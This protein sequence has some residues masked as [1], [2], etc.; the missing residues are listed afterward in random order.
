MM[1]RREFQLSA[2]SANKFWKITLNGKAYTVQFGRVGSAGQTQTKKFATTAEAV[3][4]FDRLIQEKLKK[5]YQE[6]TKGAP[7]AA[8]KLASKGRKVK[9]DRV[10]S[11]PIPI[12]A[13]TKVTRSLALRPEEWRW[14]RW[15]N[16]TPLDLPPA[17][18]FNRAQTIEN[19]FARFT[20][21][22]LSMTHEEAIFWFVV[23]NKVYIEDNDKFAA[24]LGKAK[25]PDRVTLDDVKKL[26]IKH[27]GWLHPKMIIPLYHL[28]TPAQLAEIFIMEIKPRRYY[29]YYNQDALLYGL[30]LYLWPYLN[31]GM[32]AELRAYVNEQ[33]GKA[34]KW[35]YHPKQSPTPP[36]AYHFAAFLGD[37]AKVNNLLESWTQE[38]FQDVYNHA[39]STR[40]MLFVLNDPELAIR[41]ARR[42]KFMNDCND[43]TSIR[44]Q[45]I[46]AWL[47][48]TEF[49]A[50]DVIRDLI[51]L[52]NKKV[53]EPAVSELGLVADAPEVAPL[54][55]EYTF[56]LRTA[57]PATE[58]LENHPVN[59]IMGLMPIATGQGRSA[60]AALNYLRKQRRKGH[61]ELIKNLAKVHAPEAA[62]HL[63]AILTV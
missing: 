31:E 48:M 61:L 47:A 60:D 46:R 22:P 35:Q 11:A 55:L 53:A 37:Q 15:R 26:M 12:V 29:I 33:G 59:G 32:Q 54:M 44:K 6:I 8:G 24:T 18:P 45:L 50:L 52:Y 23:I 40:L 19:L 34:L 57:K 51:P 62:D 39:Y 9:D 58:W 27:K 36:A 16:L 3:K 1:L 13:D 7:K 20:E 63:L 10:S 21:L 30:W 42:L 25:F 41:H 17:L 49:R 38:F 2:G 4:S 14:A 28:L 56:N 43:D 5:G